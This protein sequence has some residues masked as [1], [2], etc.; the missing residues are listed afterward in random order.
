[1]QGA[2]YARDFLLDITR[3]D[4]D[5]VVREVRLV[6]SPAL[7][8]RGPYLLPQ[9][10]AC[11]LYTLDHWK[12][13]IDMMAEGGINQIHWW[14]AGLYP[15]K[16]YPETFEITNTKMSVADVRELCKYAQ[17]R[18]MKFLVGGG[19]FFW[20]GIQKIADTHPQL[21]AVETG[22]LCPSQPESQRIMT[23]YALEWL[24]TFPEADGLWIE[25]RDEGGLC[26]CP[27][28]SKSLDGFKS[29][30]YGQSEILFLKTLMKQVWSGHPKAKLVW[31]VEY[32]SGIP[33]MPHFDDPL[34][35]ERMRE[36]KDTRIEW[37]VVWEQFK[38]PGPGNQNLPVPFFTRNALHWDKPYWPNLQNVFAHAKIAAEQ[39]YL[40]YSNAWEIG[41]ASND[42][43]MRRRSL[44][45]GHHSRD[46]HEPG[47]PRGLLGTVADLG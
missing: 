32:H 12:H 10:G 46:R 30:Q 11:P 3:P 28:C 35:F 17:A 42:W 24:D 7:A 40:G 2:I 9:Y 47:L 15:S 34:Y 44:S 38:L 45:G 23:E 37:M 4:R 33:T 43:Y 41:F 36:I 13:I 14:V 39:G 16:K 20:H 19:G 8:V 18:G 27:F 29:R 1:M 21:K 31:L 22:G 6:R 5:A 26:K 25:P